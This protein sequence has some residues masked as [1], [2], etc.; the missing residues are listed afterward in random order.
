MTTRNPLTAE[1]LSILAASPGR[2]VN[3]RLDGVL[4]VSGQPVRYLNIVSLEHNHA[5]YDAYYG[6]RKLTLKIDIVAYRHLIRHREQITFLMQKVQQNPDGVGQEA[7]GRY[8][9]LFNAKIITPIDPALLARSG[10]TSDTEGTVS[11]L[12][13]QF[14]VEF[15]LIEP[16]VSDFRSAGWGGRTSGTLDQVLKTVLGY[17]LGPAESKELLIDPE[18]IGFRGV[19]VRSLDNQ[20]SYEHIVIPAGTLVC[21]IPRFLQ[22][23]YGLYSSGLGFSIWQGWVCLF[24]LYSY[25]FFKHQNRT[26][27]ILNI[28]ENEIPTMER[29]FLYRDK[30]LYVFATGQSAQLDRVSQVQYNHGNGVRFSRA[31][32]LINP[33]DEFA[34]TST[35]K[36][37]FSRSERTVEFLLDGK[38]DGKSLVRHLPTRFTD[39]PYK[40]TSELADQMGTVI[41]IQWDRSAPELLYPGMQVKYLYKEGDAIKGLY[42]TVMGVD[43]VTRTAS[44]SITDE[45]Y[46]T[47]S[48]LTLNVQRVDL[49]DT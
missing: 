39:N 34:K 9:Q 4:M 44:G 10:N 15:D 21:E 33:D 17:R 6:T 3:W 8:V 24:P 19:D 40:V 23:H 28:P 7:A 20:K 13:R 27:T 1:E 12:S 2:A 16:I 5:F 29:T 30:Q 32:D 49:L 38:K 47:T 18:Y 45:H 42:G 14:E 22:D 26:L 11:Q 41:T 35:N 36:T 37:T 43:S 48:M 31:S 25:N 46:I